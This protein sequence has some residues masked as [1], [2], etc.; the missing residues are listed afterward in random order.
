MNDAAA[1]LNFTPTHGSFDLKV[2]NAQTDATV[3]TNISIDLD[4]IGADTG[5]DDLQ[6][7]IDAIANVS[8]TITTDGRL[9][10][11][12]GSGFE[13]RFANDDSGVLAAL[14]I[15][16]FFTG[17]ASDDIAVSELVSGDHRFLAN[18][19]GG[20]ASDNRNAVKMAQ[21]I[22]N[23]V[24]TIGDTTLDAYY[25]TL[26]SDIAQSTASQS[27]IARGRTGFRD[28]LL[29]QREQFSGVSLD[30]EAIMILQFQRGFQSAARLISII[31]ELFNVLLT[32]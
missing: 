23:P 9:K 6:A 17:S 10:I 22:D 32:M 19:L 2:T 29:G 3:T 4:G 14:G 18:S 24:A 11:D 16:V 5:L 12:A 21:F 31:D 30:E 8:A 28:S 25:N 15:N 7:A 20:G 1:G 27:V 26:I 13:F